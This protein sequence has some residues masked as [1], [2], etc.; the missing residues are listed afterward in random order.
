M[1]A[2]AQEIRADLEHILEKQGIKPTVDTEYLTAAA[3]GI[4]REMG[5]YMLKRRPVDVEGATH[6]ACTLLLSGMKTLDSE[7]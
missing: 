1:Q 3:I 2:V 6:F 5:D 4:A 7:R